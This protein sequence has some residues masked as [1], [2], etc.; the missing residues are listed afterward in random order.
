MTVTEFAKFK[1]LPPFTCSSPEI[2]EFLAD[3]GTKQHAFSGYPLRFYQDVN[4]PDVVYLVSGWDTVEDHGKWSA[5]DESK[6]VIERC[7]LEK[8]VAIEGL[9]HLEVE[10]PNLPDEWKGIAHVVVEKEGTTVA[11]VNAEESFKNATYQTYVARDQTSPCGE[12]FQLAVFKDDVVGLEG[13]WDGVANFLA[14]N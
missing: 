10:F 2:L 9:A 5:T 14:V 6:K 3:V 11:D 12:V 8:L 1:V 13:K 7:M 4:S